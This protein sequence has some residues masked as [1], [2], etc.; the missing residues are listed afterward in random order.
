MYSTHTVQEYTKQ[1]GPDETPG[2]YKYSRVLFLTKQYYIPITT[3]SK[4]TIA[5]D[6]F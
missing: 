6:Q 2:V 5:V 3:G 1:Q 4:Y